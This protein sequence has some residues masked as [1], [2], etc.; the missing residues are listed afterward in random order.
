MIAPIKIINLVR[1][2]ILFGNEIIMLFLCIVFDF[3]FVR[4]Y[5]TRIL[6]DYSFGEN[7]FLSLKYYQSVPLYKANVTKWYHS[8]AFYYRRCF[9]FRDAFTGIIIANKFD[10]QCKRSV[11]YGRRALPP[12]SGLF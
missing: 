5:I 3:V 10:H 1:S 9:E 12:I 2:E 11:I 8:S 6:P 4:L 7:E